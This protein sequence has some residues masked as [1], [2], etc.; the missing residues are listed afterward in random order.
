MKPQHSQDL[1]QEFT[2]WYSRM[3]R[4]PDDFMCFPK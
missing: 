1:I 4:K 3:E 2:F